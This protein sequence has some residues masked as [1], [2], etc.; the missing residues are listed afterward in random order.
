MEVKRRAVK[1]L[2]TKLSS[3]SEQTRTEA[4][5]EL[6]LISKNDSDSRS[7]IGDAGAVPYLSESLYS[8]NKLA[9]ENATATLH[10]L[11]ISSKDLL[12]STRG[13]LDALSHALRNPSSPS[14][15]Q[16]AAATIFSLLTAESYRPI[17]GHK[18]D[19]LFGLIDII[20]SPNSDSRTVKDALKALF[21]IALYPLNRAQIIELG[22][23][24]PLFSLLCNDGRVGILEDVTAVIAQI[25]GCEESWEAFR[26][27]SGVGVLVDLLDSST[28]SS[29]RTKENAVS[30]LLN[31][32][33]YGVEE[34]SNSVRGIVLGAVDGII[35]VAEN[36][37]DKGRSKA[38]ALLKIV[39]A[40]SCMFQEEQMDCLSNHSL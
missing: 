36:G 8:S 19:I 20:K 13:I 9:Q 28:G 4:I 10:N 34:T 22:A 25:A 6:R 35:E 2:V 21:G 24:T 27:I 23:V 15:A 14:V 3:V 16:C 33:Q 40:S 31:L 39:D 30:A 29:S 11:S 32:V 37:T 1:N 7:L 38:M 17:I 18:R 5:C 12:M 26:K